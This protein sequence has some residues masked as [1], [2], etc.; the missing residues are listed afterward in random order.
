MY[1]RSRINVKVEPRSN[2]RFTGGTAIHCLNF[3]YVGQFT[4]VQAVR[5]KKL[6]DSGNPPEKTLLKCRAYSVPNL[7]NDLGATTDSKGVR[8]K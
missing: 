4:C 6:R 3:S 5:T 2:L 1:E 7:I 8:T